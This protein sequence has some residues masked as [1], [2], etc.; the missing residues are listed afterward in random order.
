[1]MRLERQEGTGDCSAKAI[2][3]SEETYCCLTRIEIVSVVSANPQS[4]RKG[5]FEV[6]STT[7]GNSIILIEVVGISSLAPQS[8]TE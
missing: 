3:T 8:N 5:G 6:Q 7:S 1:M 2:K 4:S